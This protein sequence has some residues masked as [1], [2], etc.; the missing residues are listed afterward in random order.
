MYVFL[1]TEDTTSA[2]LRRMKIRARAEEAG[3]ARHVFTHR[4]WEMKLYVC[5][6]S[7]IPAEIVTNFYTLEGM[8]ILPVPTAVR[9]AKGIAEKLLSGGDPV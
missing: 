1:L 5:R 6:A 4:V 2:A 8:N 7:E 3:T 9:A